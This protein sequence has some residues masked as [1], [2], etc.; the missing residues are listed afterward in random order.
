LKGY[1]GDPLA[2]VGR[3]IDHVQQDVTPDHYSALATDEPE[4]L[5]YRA[6]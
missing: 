6:P 3:V 1:L 4:M 2:M 5:R